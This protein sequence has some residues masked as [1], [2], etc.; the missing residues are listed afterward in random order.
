MAT[1][2][3]EK[4]KE[5]ANPELLIKQAAEAYVYSYPLV[6]WGVSMEV[7]TNVA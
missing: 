6:V 1:S 5:L 2:V 3:L 4:A 7:L